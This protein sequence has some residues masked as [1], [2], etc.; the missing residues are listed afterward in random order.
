MWK[1]LK[2]R[3]C[4]LEQRVLEL[5]N[6][7]EGRIDHFEEAIEAVQSQLQELEDDGIFEKGRIQAEKAMQD[8]MDA[9]FNYT[10]ASMTGGENG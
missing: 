9:I 4:S 2:A 7:M 3:I 5:E 6:E 1:K 8:G 10:P